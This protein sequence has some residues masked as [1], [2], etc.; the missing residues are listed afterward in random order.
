MIHIGL[1]LSSSFSL[2]SSLSLPSNLPQTMASIADLSL[3]LAS[4]SLESSINKKL[5][6][7]EEVRNE[8]KVQESQISHCWVD[9]CSRH[10]HYN[11]LKVAVAVHGICT[12][13]VSV[14]YEDPSP[15]I[16]KLL[17]QLARALVCGQHDS[18]HHIGLILRSLQR[19]TSEW[20]ERVRKCRQYW[21]SYEWSDRKSELAW[22]YGIADNSSADVVE[23]YR[24]QV[25]P[26]RRLGGNCRRS[27]HGSSIHEAWPS[28]AGD[29]S[30]LNTR[31]PPFVISDNQQSRASASIGIGYQPTRPQASRLGLFTNLTLNPTS[32]P[33]SAASSQPAVTMAFSVQKQQP[34]SPVQHILTRMRSPALHNKAGYIY[35]F[36]DPRAPTLLKIGFT[37]TWG[38]YGD[39]ECSQRIY[40]HRTMC[41]FE[42][43][44]KFYVKMACGGARIESLIHATLVSKKRTLENCRCG[45]RHREWYDVSVHEAMETTLLWN[46]FSKLNPWYS[47]GQLKPWWDQY[48]SYFWYDHGRMSIQ[49]WIEGPWARALQDEESAMQECGFGTL[50]VYGASH[51]VL[52][53]APHRFLL[54]GM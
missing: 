22:N 28:N 39:L 4:I 12:S 43:D 51:E 9:C 17:A 27:T 53:H 7:A 25:E 49:E 31:Q 29:I 33:S 41:G 19:R 13:L 37:E 44:I 34:N 50:T 47:W 21:P 16:D 10:L 38:G 54:R 6:R 8:L 36:S 18:A 23:A 5:P 26:L 24:F 46:R 3:A 32:T 45:T 1:Y 42:P 48:A 2:S 40:R 52:S 11:G 20:W 30:G 15:A 14:S 35:C